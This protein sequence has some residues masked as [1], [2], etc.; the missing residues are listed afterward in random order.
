MPRVVR[1]EHGAWQRVQ[2]AGIARAKQKGV[3]C[4]RAPMTQPK[5][6][7]EVREAYLDHQI[8]YREVTARWK[9]H[10]NKTPVPPPIHAPQH[11]RKPANLVIVWTRATHATCANV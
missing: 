8:T 6:Y 9:S 4:G 2:A 1:I 11:P 10:N 3:H 7:G 5:N